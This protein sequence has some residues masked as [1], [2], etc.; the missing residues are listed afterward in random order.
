MWRIG[1][2]ILD[3]MTPDFLASVPSFLPTP[4]L[5]RLYG[6][7]DSFLSEL[8]RAI[9]KAPL[10]RNTSH[11][12]AM[13]SVFNSAHTRLALNCFCSTLAAGIPPNFHV[14]IALDSSSF[15]AM[16]PFKRDVLLCD[17]SSRNFTLENHQ[18]FKDSIGYYVIA[19]GVDLIWS[20]ADVIFI[21]NPMELFRSSSLMEVSSDWMALDFDPLY[22]YTQFNIGFMR[23]ISCKRSVLLWS[24]LLRIAL[25]DTSALEQTMMCD[26]LKLL[27]I[28]PNQTPIQQYR[29]KP[30]HGMDAVYSIRFY[31]P[32]EVMNSGLFVRNREEAFAFARAKRY[33]KPW[34]IHLA[35]LG[36]DEKE[37]ALNDADLWFYDGKQ[38]IKNPPGAEFPDLGPRNTSEGVRP[39]PQTSPPGQMPLEIHNRSHSRPINGSV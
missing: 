19:M 39:V 31:H 18:R 33:G 12:Q 27:R 35:Y 29:M 10:N 5:Q 38:C 24:R 22:D 14:W 2:S 28:T 9:F 25:A 32:F 7:T 21:K 15:R 23:I 30:Q 36:E 20:D 3:E 8:R 37:P 1:N 17:I 6:V 4:E 11:H 34:V 13:V 26:S 16:L